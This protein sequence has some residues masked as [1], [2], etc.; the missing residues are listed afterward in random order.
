MERLEKLVKKLKKNKK[1]II[2]YSAFS[3]I[4]LFSILNVGSDMVTNVKLENGYT[5]ETHKIELDSSYKGYFGDFYL[6]ITKPG[7]ELAYNYHRRHRR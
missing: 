3:I 4:G 1:K 7:R 5:P 2:I 6:F